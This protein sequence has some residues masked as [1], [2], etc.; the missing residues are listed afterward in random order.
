MFAEI[1][2]DEVEGYGIDARVDVG[3]DEAEN[4][5]RVPVLVVPRLGSRVKVKPQ[6]VDVNRQETDGEQAHETLRWAK[7]CKLL[8]LK[9]RMNE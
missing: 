3:Q 7:R 9:N 1:G 5:E 2:A 6:R 8:I 4:P